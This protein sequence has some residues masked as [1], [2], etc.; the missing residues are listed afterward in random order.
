MWVAQSTDL[1]GLVT[2][3]DTLPALAA[4]LPG[5]VLDLLEGGDGAEIEIPI[6]VI[7]SLSTKVR[8]RKAA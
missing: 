6:E 4:K 7:A 1:P 2:E 3:A 5:M 8:A